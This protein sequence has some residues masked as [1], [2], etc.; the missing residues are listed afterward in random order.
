MEE[1]DILLEMKVREIFIK[2]PSVIGIFKKYGL[3][4]NE[5]FFSEKV[6]L[7]EALE[8]LRLPSKEV[9]KEIENCLKNNF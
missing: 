6:N 9:I 4:C 3:Q 1:K 7:R 5:C 8:S 2:Y